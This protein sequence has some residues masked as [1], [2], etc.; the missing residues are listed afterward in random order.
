MNHKEVVGV[1]GSGKSRELASEFLQ[2]VNQ[3]VAASLIDPHG[4][5]VDLILGTLADQGYFDHPDAYRRVRYID[6]SNPSAFPPFNILKQPYE[7]HAAAQ[8]MLEAWKRSWSSIA[9]GDAPNLEQM[10]LSGALVLIENGRP[11]TNLALLFGDA[12]FRERLLQQVSDRQVAQFFRTYEQWG[13]RAGILS[14]STLRRSFLLTYSPALRYSLGQVENGLRIRE[15]MDQ[16]V[17]VFYNL[18]GLDEET[19]RFLGCLLTVGY[20]VAALSRADVAE[21]RRT[22][23]CL[24]LDEYSMFSAQS[25]RAMERA[26]ALT[27][28]YGLSLTLA[29]QTFSQ[30]DRKLAGALQNTTLVAFRLGTEDAAI[31]ASRLGVYDPYRVKHQVANRVYQERS[32]PVYM[33][34]SEQQAELERELETLKA[35]EAYVRLGA[36]TQ[37]ILTLGVPDPTCSEARLR[38][39]KDNY[40]RLYLTPLADVQRLEAELLSGAPQEKAAQDATAVGSAGRAVG[41]H[42]LRRRAPLPQR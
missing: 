34:R 8:N 18:G 37:K 27:R 20:E 38:A 9:G 30:I 32:H 16:G 1:T 10:L 7:S 26:L 39:I 6:F 31:G 4:D 5:L 17:S 11:L 25:E 24:I 23:H 14:E 36:K 3:G 33:S 40:A 13:K 29:H 19:Q 12:T 21:A 22:P 28:K 42:R 35:R 41:G 2:R 15:L